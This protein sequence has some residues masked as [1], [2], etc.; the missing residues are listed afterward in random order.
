[1]EVVKINS[2]HKPGDILDI[3]YQ[4]RGIE[5]TTKLTLTENPAMEIVSIEKTGG[6]LTPA[7]QNFRTNW[8]GSQVKSKTTN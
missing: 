8:L 2:D 7:M 4:H 6:T 5:K 1:M 3:T